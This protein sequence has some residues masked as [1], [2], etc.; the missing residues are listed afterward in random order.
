MPDAAPT[1]QQRIASDPKI[2]AWV[3]ANAGS[4][5]TRVLTQRVARLLLA[6]ADPGKILCL[7]YTKAAAAEMQS[8]LFSLLGE[9]SMQPDAALDG[10]LKELGGETCMTPPALLSRARRLFAHALET[11]GGLKIQT[12]HAFCDSVLR[13]FPLEAGVS[14]NFE[15]IDDR[16]SAI[17]LADIRDRMARDAEAGG[18]TA[19]DLIASRLNEDA[20][21]EIA[22]EVLSRRRG[23][24]ENS[25]AA[26]LVDTF[27]TD[28]LGD[29]EPT[30]SV[31]LEGYVDRMSRMADVLAKGLKKDV[32]LS[33]GIRGAIASVTNDP[34]GSSETLANSLLVKSG[35]RRGQPIKGVPTKALSA[36]YPWLEIE[37]GD[38]AQF[39]MHLIDIVHAHDAASRTGDLHRFAVALLR[40]YHLAKAEA[41]LLDFEDL[42][43]RTRDLLVNTETRS[44]VLYKLDH[45]LEH[46]LVDEAQDTAPEQW[47][48]I[49]A[50]TDDFYAGLAASDAPDGLQRTVF[51]VGDEKQSIYSFQGAEPG[52]FGAMR[53]KL[54]DRLSGLGTRLERP[55]LI[56]SFRSAPTILDFVDAVFDGPT[57]QGVTFTGDPIRHLASRS[58]DH[59]W[60]DLWPL[61]E[62]H[63]DPDENPWWEPVDRPSPD[64]PR[65][66]L[67]D[68]LADRIRIMVLEGTLP[69]RSGHPDRRIRP[70]DILVLV[71]RRDRLARRLIDAL[72]TEGVP[73]SGSDR[74]GLAEELA[75][76]DVLALIRCVL[77]PA[78][79]LSLACALRSPLGSLSEQDLFD[80]AHGRT[81]T[82]RASLNDHAAR[83]PRDAAMLNDLSER[84]GALGPYEFLERV[85]IKHDGR[86][87]L[88]ARLGPEAEDCIDEL[89]AQALVYE[90]REVPTLPG[91]TAWIEAGDVTLKRE[92]DKGADE[93]RVMTIH[94]AKGL[95][96]PVVILPDTVG[97]GGKGARPLLLPTDPGAEDALVLWAGPRTT[98]DAATARARAIA[99]AR[100][101]AES[102]RLLYVGLTR[103]EDWLI[104]CGAGRPSDADKGWY[105]LLQRAAARFETHPASAPEG[106]DGMIRQIRPAVIRLSSDVQKSQIKEIFSDARDDWISPAK[107][108]PRLR[109]ISPSS[110]AKKVSDQP[111]AGPS[112]PERARIRGKAIHHLLEHLPEVPFD[113]RS[114]LSDRLLE[115]F[116]P[117]LP[118]D[119]QLDV[120]AEV[121]AVLT[122]QELAALFGMN[123]MGEVP[124]TIPVAADGVLP[125]QARIDRLVVEPGRV[126][127]VDYKTDETVPLSPSGVS[128]SYLA[129]LGAYRAAVALIYP[130]H[131]VEAAILWTRSRRL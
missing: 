85:L 73:V 28:V 121:D 100:E 78:D 118:A 55:A 10:M 27:G 98:D 22:T 65:I 34:R 128:K 83:F 74:L 75:V 33:Q 64:D 54:G 125:M 39:A 119:L 68:A 70:G 45:G 107:R 127:I 67:A 53:Q 103:A 72:K 88:I 6:G 31:E 9:W 120:R 35:D 56:T 25:L 106:V 131:L 79:D 21:K 94:G 36:D 84:V 7:T 51:V 101:E 26:R 3:G 15:V 97:G 5:K 12:I 42:V 1:D 11:P 58:D 96:A 20:L 14:P 114:E 59:G 16:Q 43:G 4:G 24:A 2:S 32:A 17:L 111:S 112:D 19:F 80:L 124:L 122:S 130:A 66:R 61:I 93:V 76:K 44:W 113:Q 57:V 126:L 115:A 104:I 90:A 99:T 117:N 77:T 41:G 37:V 105:G 123:S 29:L 108:E 63:D 48:I 47:D 40:R 95:E 92:M 81:G 60:I 13:R 23:F 129:Q 50:I 8:R 110:L 71:R 30:L 91:F 82:L 49:S 18:D 87:R 69:P 46:I 116:A 102:K 89:I 86:R 62:K 109:R 52:A 38:L